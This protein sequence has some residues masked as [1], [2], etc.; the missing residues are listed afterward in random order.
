MCAWFL[1]LLPNFK[2]WP[3]GG[4]NKVNEEATNGEKGVS[5]PAST[6]AATDADAHAMAV[7]K[8]QSSKMTTPQDKIIRTPATPQQ[9]AERPRLN[10][11]VQSQELLAQSTFAKKTT[12][13]NKGKNKRGHATT[14]KPRKAI[15]KSQNA[16]QNK[17]PKQNRA[18]QPR[19]PCKATSSHQ[20]HRMRPHG[21]LVLTC[22]VPRA[23]E[24]SLLQAQPKA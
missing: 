23:S 9:A 14:K 4:P 11:R 7:A 15:K 18:N 21:H 16:K 17:Q 20:Q 12:G 1:I 19:K 8:Y 6:I 10:Q 5:S 22:Q 2:V 3:V 24:K 13:K